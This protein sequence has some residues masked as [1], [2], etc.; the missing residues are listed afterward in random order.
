MG[1][2]AE[3]IREGDRLAL[4]RLITDIENGGGEFQQQLDLLYPFTG[5]AHIIGITGPSGSG[6]S[7]L[8]NQ[9]AVALKK[10]QNRPQK[11]IGII[12]VDPTSPFT[13][14]ALLGDRVRMQSLSQDK[15]IFI[16]SMA[17]RGALGGIALAT[18][19]TALAMDAAGFDTILIETVGAG[20]SEVEIAS[21]THTTIVVE[22]PGLGD[23][24]Q[25]AKA[26]I[27]EIADILVVNK[28]DKPGADIT[29][30]ALQ[31]MLAIG[32]ELQGEMTSRR[33]NVPV[34]KTSAIDNEGVAELANLIAV[35][36]SFLHAT[37]EWEKCSLQRLAK[38]VHALL[39][40]ALFER[41]EEKLD[42]NRYNELMVQVMQRA[43]SP[44][45]AVQKLLF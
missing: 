25:A 45:Q 32:D 27:L 1:A 33:W 7:T 30:T 24:V 35:H 14:G 37:G 23:E 15:D 43:I 26:G 18:D 40:D 41:W 12:A 28:A 3:R 31:R 22:A 10:D 39:R 36:K 17:T 19:N 11:K 16:R 44:H 42:Q 38:Q 13:G 29:A 8:V 9:L 5:N 4:S 2:K 6:K 34:L 21:L 20:Q